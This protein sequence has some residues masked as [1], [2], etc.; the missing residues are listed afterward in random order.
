MEKNY[1][2]KD[3]NDILMSKKLDEF[4][5]ATLE[6][7]NECLSNEEYDKI[8]NTVMQDEDDNVSYNDTSKEEVDKVIDNLLDK[9]D[10][11]IEHDDMKKVLFG[12]A[13][14][15]EIA[16]ITM[17]DNRIYNLIGREFI[18]IHKNKIIDYENVTNTCD[19]SMARIVI[20]RPEDEPSIN[21]DTACFYIE[22][23]Y[24]YIYDIYRKVHGNQSLNDDL[25]S[26]F[27]KE[28]QEKAKTLTFKR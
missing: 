3:I 24:G 28:N 20:A 10:L 25:T 4:Y 18:D 21:E 7:R 6:K 2:Q 26:D 22:D 13:Q 19:E 5:F 12:F 23:E 17:I 27:V 14:I 11:D 9:A 1:A 15:R 16:I 8:F